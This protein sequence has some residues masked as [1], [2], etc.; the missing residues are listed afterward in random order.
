MLFKI[1]CHFFSFIPPFLTVGQ[2]LGVTP[3]QEKKP[4][5]LP[6]GKFYVESF[7]QENY[8]KTI[9]IQE[10]CRTLKIDSVFWS[11]F[12]YLNKSWV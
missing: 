12:K 11:S 4:I 3:N 1:Y 5:R 8:L 2:I 7:E 9:I 6:D 10:A